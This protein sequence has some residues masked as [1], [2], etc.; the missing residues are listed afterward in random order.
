MISLLLTE[1]VNLTVEFASVWVEEGKYMELVCN[2][3]GQPQPKL[4]WSRNGVKLQSDGGNLTISQV[5]LLDHG[6]YTCEAR[7]E[8]NIATTSTKVNVVPFPH[9]TVA[10]PKVIA[11]ASG[12]RI[13]LECQ[14]TSLSN[15]TWQRQDNYLFSSHLEHSSGTL[16]LRNV[17]SSGV[18]LC[19]VNTRFRSISTATHVKVAYPSCSHLKEAFPSSPSGTYDIDPDGEGSNAPYKVHCDMLDKNG[20]GVT[21]IGHNKEERGRTKGCDW[22]GCIRVDVKYNGTTLKQLESLTKAALHCEQFIMF[23]CENG[24]EFIE[25]NHAWWVSRHGTPKYYWG[26]ATPGSRRCA[27]GMN[28]SCVGGGRCN[29]KNVGSGWRDDSGLLTD[30]FS[31]PVT[32]LRFG[33]VAAEDNEDGYYTLGKF[34]CYGIITTKGYY[35]C[36]IFQLQIV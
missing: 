32:Q 10:P 31:L 15:I 35:L 7:N 28:D 8:V 16:V 3:T 2:A 34:K 20:V 26:G 1:R 11:V 21:V 22:P 25:V 30:K 29:C 9:F 19:K 18:Y 33:D 14:G 24:V 17:S 4:T 23:E 27:C 6:T 36:F 5:S 12:S 13:K